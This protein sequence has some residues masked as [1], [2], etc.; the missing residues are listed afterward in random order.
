M[1]IKFNGGQKSEGNSSDPKGKLG[2]PLKF[3]WA[4]FPRETLG[5]NGIF[6]FKIRV[7]SARLWGFMKFDED[8]FDFAR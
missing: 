7:K 6:S 8:W 1:I 3:V 4:T 5:K 2:S